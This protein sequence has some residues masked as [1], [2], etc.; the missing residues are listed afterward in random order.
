MIL[1]ASWEACK[2]F[3]ILFISDTHCYYENINKQIDYAQSELGA[4]VSCVIHLGDFG[5]YRPNLH[6]FFI[7]QQQRFLRPVYCID[8]NHEDFDALPVL[9]KK[10]QGCFTYMPRASVHEIDGY[11]FL[12][13]GGAGYMDSMITQMGA[14]IRDCTI[15]A[16]LDI[17]PNDV[18][19]ILTHDCPTGIGVPNTPGME[20]YGE[21]GFP[22]S[23]ELAPHFR[24]KLWLFGHH[25]K[26]FEYQDDCTRYF[27][28]ASSWRGFGLL[29]RNYE[30][31][32]IRHTIPYP[33][34]KKSFVM[35]M[36]NRLRIIQPN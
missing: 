9:V 22:R 13:L 3:M 35:R 4:D 27:G 23:Q 8:G 2:R 28:L 31:T 5:I 12:A 24:P 19:I 18:D 15:N 25:H 6:R 30:L 17:D 33:P 16:C 11:R 26:W 36:L 20:H 10:Y 1:P 29:S 21:P 34:E 14:L 7:K 32:L